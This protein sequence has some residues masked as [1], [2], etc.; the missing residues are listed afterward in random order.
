MKPWRQLRRSLSTTKHK[1]TFLATN[2]SSW[3]SRTT[4]TSRSIARESCP[5]G[6]KYG[7][8]EISEPIASSSWSFYGRY[9]PGDDLGAGRVRQGHGRHSFSGTTWTL[10][11]ECRHA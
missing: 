2:S 10:L 4:T 6:R 3:T 5:E 11:Q 7:R 1:S 8:D 9:H